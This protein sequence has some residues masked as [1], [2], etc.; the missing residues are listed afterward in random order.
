VYGRPLSECVIEPGTSDF[1]DDNF[2]KL[3][4][5]TPTESVYVTPAHYLQAIEE[6]RNNADL[7]IFDTQT[8]EHNDETAIFSDTVLPLMVAREAVALCLFDE[9]VPSVPNGLNIIG[10][11]VSQGA[12]AD[13]FYALFN[14]IKSPMQLDT[15]RAN[16]QG[17]AHLVGVVYDLSDSLDPGAISRALPSNSDYAL[18]LLRFLFQVTGNGVYQD[19]GDMA[20]INPPTV[21]E[22]LTG[23]IS[24]IK[25]KIL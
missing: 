1:G 23:W 10:L 17:M 21:S 4:A 9:S 18:A 15:A 25:K 2:W 22:P 6:L 7:I 14:R 5:P 12:R 11:L 13:D 24:K 20:K 3:L 8:A 16:I 19:L